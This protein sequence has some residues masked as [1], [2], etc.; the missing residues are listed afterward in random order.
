MAAEFPESRIEVTN[1]NDIA[2]GIADLNPIAYPVRL[3]NEDVYPGDET[4][5]RGLNGQAEND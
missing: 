1:V 5:H 2:S 4:F 3:T